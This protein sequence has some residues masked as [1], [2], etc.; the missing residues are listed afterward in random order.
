VIEQNIPNPFGKETA[1]PYTVYD[2][3]QSAYIMIRDLNS[4]ELVRYVIK[5]KG[6]LANRG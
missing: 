1:I 2:M 5:A 6:K 4:R 3:Q